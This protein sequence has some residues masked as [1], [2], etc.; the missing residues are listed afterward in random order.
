MISSN[1]QSKVAQFRQPTYEIDPV[2]VNR[3]SPRSF[4]EK[5]VPEEVLLSLFEAARWAPSAFNLQPWRFIIAR[6][7]EAR[8]QFHSFIGEFN[9]TWCKKAP[10]FTLIIS[11]VTS[12]HGDNRSHAFD[13]GAAWGSLSLEAVHKGLITHPMTGIDFDKAREVLQ[14]PDD[15]AINALVAIGYQGEK[16]ALPEALQQREQPSPRRPLEESIFEGSFG[17]PLK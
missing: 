8:E 15:Y 16:D 4:S 14:I 7:Q 6:S 10:A 2:F 12:E 1:S 17:Q 9:L 5:E 13:T 3:W 11:K